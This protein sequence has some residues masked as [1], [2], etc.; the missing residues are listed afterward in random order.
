LSVNRVNPRR[1]LFTHRRKQRRDQR[2][3]PQSLY[4]GQHLEL[5]LRGAVNRASYR[6]NSRLSRRTQSWG[7]VLDGGT[8]GSGEKKTAPTEADPIGCGTP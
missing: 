3:E 4:H 1:K 5:R 7:G 6:M 8:L 2:R